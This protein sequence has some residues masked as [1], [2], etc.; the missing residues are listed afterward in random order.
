MAFN[1]GKEAFS[2]ATLSTDEENYVSEKNHLEQLASPSDNL[3]YDNVEEEPELTARTWIAL[4][5]MFL[6]NLVQ[7]L[8][9]Q[10]PPAVVSDIKPSREGRLHS[11]HCFHKALL[12]WIGLCQLSSLDLGAKL[13]LAR[14]GSLIATALL[15]FGHIPSSQEFT[16]WHFHHI[17][18]RS[19]NCSRFS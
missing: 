18:H 9:L 10:G 17:L 11:D 12:Y 4:G 5:A 16:R 2:P 19:G 6:L 8:A 1:S 13:T 14:S 3:V 7:V 15:H